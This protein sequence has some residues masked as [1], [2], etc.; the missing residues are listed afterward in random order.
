M[1]TGSRMRTHVQ[2][3]E[4]FPLGEST[5]VDVARFFRGFGADAVFSVTSADPNVVAATLDG[6]VLTLLAVSAG[7]AVVSITANEGDRSV[8]RTL[9]VE[10]AEECPAYAC[11]SWTDGWRLQIL[12][13]SLKPPED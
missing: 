12:L 9:F 5:T 11:R 10:I 2:Q 3:V 6:S 8:T 4:I 7:E 1:D 13:D